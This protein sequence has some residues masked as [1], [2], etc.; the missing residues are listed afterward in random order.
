MNN[1][2][3]C[4]TDRL[5]SSAFRPQ[6]PPHRPNATM[7]CSMTPAPTSERSASFLRIGIPWRTTKEQQQGERKKLNYYFEAVKSAGAEPVD[8]RLNQPSADLQAQLAELDGFVLP[9]SPAD[10]DPVRYGAIK[11]IKT[12]DI[13][14]NRD[15]TDIAILDHALEAGKPV[16]AICFGCQLLNVYQN[17]TLIQDL[18]AERP[19]S[20]AHGDTDLPPGS[21][22]GDIEHPVEFSPG[23][24]LAQLN[25]SASGKVNSSHHQAIDKPGAD[26]RVTARASDG[27]IEGVEWTG[28]PNW[29]VGVQWHPERLPND[30]LSKRLFSEFVAA[31]RSA[32]GL[33][34]HKA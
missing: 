11:H 3:R 21:V 7:Q 26:L 14:D 19:R 32:R 34:V 6:L 13:D 22:K 10:V 24:L 15:Q 17:G 8:I 25:G 9:G 2:D 12:N 5:H 16:L 23:T 29:I 18:R 30:A 28:G 27:T 20:V 33:V 1:H 4:R 31:V